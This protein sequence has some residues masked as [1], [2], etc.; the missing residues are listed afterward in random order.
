MHDGSAAGLARAVG[1]C[2]RPLPS[3]APSSRTPCLLLGMA[4]A[5]AAASA[6][7][8]PPAHPL[9]RVGPGCVLG[10]AGHLPQEGLPMLCLALGARSSFPHRSDV[11]RQTRD[12]SVGNGGA[13]TPEHP[14][15]VAV[16]GRGQGRAARTATDKV[17]SRTRAPR[18][19]SLP[20][21]HPCLASISTS[22]L[23][24]V[25]PA[26]TH[27]PL[28]APASGSRQLAVLSPFANMLLSPLVP[29][30]QCR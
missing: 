15:H 1:S 23:R 21:H 24:L 20:H 16:P 27:R 9:P 7:A 17:L 6:P 11:Q 12:S 13:A 26:A 5:A 2:L 29:Q 28:R 4:P 14:A 18:N 22:P 8:R 3:A 25:R 10:G 30:N 19:P